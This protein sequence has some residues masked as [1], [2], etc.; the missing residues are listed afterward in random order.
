MNEVTEKSWKELKDIG[1][2]WLINS[3]LHLFG[4]AI[5]YEYENGDIKRVYPVRVKYRGFDEK[6]NTEGYIKVS[7]YLRR[8]I[9]ELYG[10]AQIK[11]PTE[12]NIRKS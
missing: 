6:T 8:N 9:E 2:L 11:K 4:W 5:A 7:D 1:L 10:E 3:I 12:T